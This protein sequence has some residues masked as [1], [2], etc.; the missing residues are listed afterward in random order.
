MPRPRYL[1]LFVVLGLAL[2]AVAARRYQEG[3]PGLYVAGEDG[4]G[5]VRLAGDA[6]APTWSPDGAKLAFAGGGGISVV[7][8]DGTGRS[9]VV[10]APDAGAP[11][12]SPD[13]TRIAFV[14]TEEDALYVIR[15]DGAVLT[16]LPKAS[17]PAAGAGD[18]GFAWQPPAWSPDGTTLA[19]VSWGFRGIGDAN[20]V[21]H[22]DD[23]GLTTLV[24]DVGDVC[25]PA[26]S[27]GGN[28]LAFAAEA[29]L[30]VANADGSR[31]T[32]LTPGLA[33]DLGGGE[34]CG[35]AWSPDGA[36]LLFA[37]NQGI[38][39]VDADGSDLTNLGVDGSEPAW[40]PDGTK[41][42]FYSEPP[43]D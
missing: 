35:V 25:G 18:R 16:K 29:G 19:V 9:R 21:V 23:S 7:D 32:N 41:I 1:V 36:R 12:W 22:T 37:S 43:Y 2:A 5:V 3:G 31:P 4:S 30:L 38:Q 39:V 40:S 27:P 33:F 28:K 42:A 24:E 26:W 34:A 11:V 8:A 13:G 14:A 17:L 6:V 15:P 10:D 20:H